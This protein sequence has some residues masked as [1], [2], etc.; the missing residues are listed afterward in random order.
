MNN[1]QH[2]LLL[3]N[4]AKIVD[5]IERGAHGVINAICFNCMIGNASAA[6][7]EKIRQDHISTPVLTAVYSGSE[8]P[9][10][11]M[12]LDAFACQVKDRF[13]SENTK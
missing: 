1:S 8:N 7:I 2:D 6:I 12:Q 5:F 11:Q 13:R 9:G 10:R 4:V 3:V